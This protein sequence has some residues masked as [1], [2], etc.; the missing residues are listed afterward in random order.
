MAPAERCRS[1]PFHETSRRSR[2]KMS[3]STRVSGAASSPS[4]SG[5]VA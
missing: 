3:L 5:A 2:L 1:C 4:L